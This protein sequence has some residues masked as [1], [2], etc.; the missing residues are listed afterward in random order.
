MRDLTGVLKRFK[1]FFLIMGVIALLSGT[2]Y[3]LYFTD[4]FVLQKIV[5]KNNRRVSKK[6]IIKLTGLKGG[7]RLFRISLKGVKNRIMMNSYIEDVTLARRLPDTLEVI[8]KEREPLGLVKSKG[9]FYLVDV[10]GV[11]IGEALSEDKSFYPVL[12]FRN[13]EFKKKFL[14]F[15]QWIKENSRY[16]PVY[17]NLSKVVLG[18]EKIYF[19]TKKGFIV[20]F[21][22]VCEKDWRY[23][24]RSLDRV[25]TFLYEKGL[26]DRVKL[27][28]MDYPL[29]EALIK[30]RSQRNG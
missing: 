8:V 18:E 11:I 21:P 28:R 19:Y 6:E 9:K 22:L 27:I 25:L 5:V 7:E 15:L 4:L 3:V 14:K 30:F 13:R 12:E 16:L 20:Y 17:A 10:N 1:I 29:G 26:A 2:I 23:L 24:Y